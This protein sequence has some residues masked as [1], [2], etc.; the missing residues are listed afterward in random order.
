M[1]T[2]TDW[3]VLRMLEWATGYFEQKRVPS[4]RLSIEWLLAHVLGVKRLELYLQFDRPLTAA[5]LEWLRE[6]VRRRARHEPLQYIT[7]STAFYHAE[8]MVTPAVLIPR[9]E[10]EELVEMILNDHP[11]GKRSL[12]DLGTGSGCIPIA[13]KMERPDWEVSGVELFDEALKV[14]QVNSVKNKT[15]I[16]WV[17]GDF[18][19]ED[20]LVSEKYDIVVSN[21]P[22]I[23]FDEASGM[24]RQV[25]DFEP[26]MALFCANRT[27]VYTAIERFARTHLNSNGYLYLEL[28]HDHHIEHESIFASDIWSL[29]IHHDLGGSRRFLSAKRT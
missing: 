11:S 12:V 4:P 2:S 21:P 10:T 22:Y 8:I 1:L 13:C 6:L 27:M 16:Q 9:P 3:T 26:S 24:D 20:L 5:E 15:H 17:L 29:E 25:K 19:S 7:G 14:A 28:H 18:F 23:H